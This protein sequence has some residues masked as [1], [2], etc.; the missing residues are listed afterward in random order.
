MAVDA[1]RFRG[2]IG[3]VCSGP[4][5]AFFTELRIVPVAA[6]LLPNDRILGHLLRNGNSPFAILRIFPELLH[7]G[8]DPLPNF[9]SP[10]SFLGGGEYVITLFGVPPNLFGTS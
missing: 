4:R 6:K 10:D 1:M 5:R 3:T 7:A 2:T 8:R 9:G